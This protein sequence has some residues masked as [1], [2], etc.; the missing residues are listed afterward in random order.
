MTAPLR[1]VTAIESQHVSTS[2]SKCGSTITVVNHYETVFKLE[3]GHRIVAP[4]SAP[5]VGSKRCWKCEVD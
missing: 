1:K 5:R 2:M 3:C 4:N